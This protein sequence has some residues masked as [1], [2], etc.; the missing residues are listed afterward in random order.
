[1]MEAGRKTQIAEA[2]LDPTEPAGDEWWRGAMFYEVYLRSFVD[3]NGDGIGDLP[4]L[5]SRLDYIKSLN[6]DGLWLS[7]FYPSP[8][9]DFGYDVSDL[10]DVDPMFGT[11]EDFDRL[12]AEAHERDLR[13]LIDVVPCHTSEQHEWFLE[14]RSGPDND[15]AD[16]Y[17]WADSGPDGGPPNNWLSS[18]GGPAWTWEP[19]RSQYYYHPFLEC[20]PSLNLRNPEALEA[21]LGVF[22]F[23]LDRGVDGFRLDAIQC[24]TCDPLF[25]SNPPS[26]SGDRNPSLGGGAHNPFR[27]QLHYFDR[28]VPESLPIL[29]AI[30]D[31]VRGREPERVIIGEL[32]DVDST[33]TAVKYTK[34]GERLHAVYDF[35]LINAV[36]SVQDIREL[37]EVR[38]DFL[39]SGAVM[40]VFTNHD[41]E[42]AVSNLTRFAVEAG[43]A[44]EAAK[45]LLFLQSTLQ[46]GGILFQG[47]ELGLTQPELDYEDMQ[48][49]WG[50]AFWP[51][52]SG[53][54]GVRTP[55]PWNGDAPHAGF[56]SAEKPWLPVPEPHAARAVDVQHD[57]PGSVL[58][59]LSGLLAWRRETPMLRHGHEI[60]LR[61]TDTAIIAYDRFDASC[62][63]TFVLNFALEEAGF[64]VEPGDDLLDVVGTRAAHAGDGI[65]LEP[66]GFCVVRRARPEPDAA[67]K[68]AATAKGHDH[69]TR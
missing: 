33:R 30:R 41:S 53:R 66:L 25:R 55:L 27:K 42:R 58:S 21:V 65:T 12:I 8:Q 47:E 7:P 51:D 16:W 45:L 10:C 56:T 24:L 2:L 35:D 23:W 26:P 28:D 31:A 50:K 43:K 59:F 19:R 44:K 36:E 9:E 62:R 29:E 34:H 38:E 3:S 39:G 6:V 52:F 57:D 60:V 48:D 11:L 68:H 49:P 4:G 61:G 18:F 69:E 1:M 17:V 64:D 40:N 37:L 20:Q 13:V 54:D 63:L 67:E 15:K 5:I 32:A 14:S 22:R 46:G